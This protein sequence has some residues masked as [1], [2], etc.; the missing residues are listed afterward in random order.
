MDVMMD[1]MAKNTSISNDNGRHGEG[2]RCVFIAAHQAA[3]VMPYTQH[4]RRVT[5]YAYMVAWP[6]AGPPI[7]GSLHGP[8]L[9]DS[10]SSLDGK[11]ATGCHRV[12]MTSLHVSLS[13][14]GGAV[15]VNNAI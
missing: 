2:H 14:S 15:A 5:A 9:C 13:Q 8:C 10:V 12:A 1:G 6:A 4:M 3:R 7:P 11:Q